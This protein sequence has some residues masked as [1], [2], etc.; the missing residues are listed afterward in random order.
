MLLLANLV[1]TAAS[2]VVGI[3]VIAIVMVLLGANQSNDVV[4]W[5]HDAGSWLAGPF[6]G[7]FNLDSAKADVA[8]NWGIA[9]IVYSIV[10]GLIV[11]LLAAG[12]GHGRFGRASTI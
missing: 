4:G 2:V 1:R 6:R 10:A 11:R 5:F 8:V 3:I 9:A 12:D 7:L